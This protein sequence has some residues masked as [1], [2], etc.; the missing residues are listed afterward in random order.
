MTHHA[1][2]NLIMLATIVGLMVFIYFKPQSQGVQE[3]LISSGSVEAVQHLRIVRQQQEI[4][5]K[6]MDSRWHLT[7]PVQAR[8]DEKKASDILQILMA[9]GHQR[10]P[11]ADLARFGLDQP[12]VRL[13]IDEEYFGFGG[14]APTTHQ[15]YVATGDHVYLISPRYVLA[16]P[17][18]ASDLISPELLASD[19]IPVRFELNHLTVELQN[20]NWHVT[21][22]HAGEAP[23][24][25]AIKHWT[26]LWQTTHAGA[27]T[28]GQ[29]FGSDFVEKDFI[30]ISLQNGQ[31]INL[32]ILQSETEIVFLRVDDGIGYH[33]SVDAGQQ[34]LDP[35]VTETNQTVL[36]N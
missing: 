16:L 10:F 11:L 28:L 3:Y 1:R 4:A 35:Y 18:N 9:T 26:Q 6:R 30:R 5:L 29:A 25:E 8:A 23:G 32:K 13:Y 2:L 22:P 17:S 33:L 7:K 20:E 12:N 27:V 24:K 14:F 31:K 34:L 36:E 15:Q 19:E 21:M